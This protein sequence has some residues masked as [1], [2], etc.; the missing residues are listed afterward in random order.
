MIGKAFDSLTWRRFLAGNDIQLGNRQMFMM[1]TRMGYFFTLLLFTLL[2]AAINYENSLSY[3]LTFILAALA[4]VSMLYTHRNLLGVRFL[5]GACEPVF[6]G[7]VARFRFSLRN[8]TA[9]PRY[10]IQLTRDNRAFDTIDLG[11]HAQQQVEL[12][13]PAGT[14][15]WL[16]IPDIKAQTSFPLGLLYTWTTRLCL[17]QKCLVY[18]HPAPPGSLPIPGAGSERDA[19]GENDRGED[20]AGLREYRKGD[21]LKQIHWKALA[22]GQGMQTKQ[23]GGGSGEDLWL[24]WETLDTLA[25]EKRLQQL[26]RWVL[27]AEE[28]EISYGLR[29]PGLEIRPGNGPEHRHQCLKALALFETNE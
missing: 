9:K 29:L 21:S 23:Y 1:P 24:E 22:R 28:L 13:C 8:D 25:P 6:A 17:D 7:Q 26:C 15:G 14:R 19:Q 10:Q 3:A 16:S 11:A 18:P 12:E 2:L 20:F 4:Q 5:A 27:D